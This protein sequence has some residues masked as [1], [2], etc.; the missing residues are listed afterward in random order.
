[1]EIS[2]DCGIS[3]CSGQIVSSEPHVFRKSLDLGITQNL[4]LAK[5][6]Q[7]CGGGASG[8][9]SARRVLSP[10]SPEQRRAGDNTHCVQLVW[11]PGPFSTLGGP[12]ECPTPGICLCIHR[13]LVFTP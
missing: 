10:K 8:R 2:S 1:M 9:E 3:N 13:R 7:R 5:S 6:S 4:H 12:E 11:L